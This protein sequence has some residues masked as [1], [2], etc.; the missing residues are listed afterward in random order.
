MEIKLSIHSLSA[1]W[2]QMTHRPVPVRGP[3]VWDHCCRGKLWLHLNADNSSKGIK[4]L[5]FSQASSKEQM[6]Q[7]WHIHIWHP[8]GAERQTRKYKIFWLAGFVPLVGA[9]LTSRWC[10]S[11]LDSEVMRMWRRPQIRTDQEETSSFFSPSVSST[12]EAGKCL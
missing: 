11:D 1:A 12:H 4:T 7:K 8:G 6:N 10:F 9:G 2:Y 5:L 3:V